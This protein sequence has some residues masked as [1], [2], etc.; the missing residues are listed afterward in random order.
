MATL[1]HLFIFSILKTKKKNKEICGI[2]AYSSSMHYNVRLQRH[3]YSTSKALHS[4][5]LLNALYKRS[6][7][8]LAGIAF[9]FPF[10]WRVLCICF[11][12]FANSQLLLFVLRPRDDF[13][14]FLYPTIARK[15]TFFRRLQKIGNES[16]SFY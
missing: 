12:F 11:Y 2:L 5:Y 14:P 13:I 4:H 10:V 3:K 16:L 6:L 1:Y 9:F 8:I 7:H 15:K